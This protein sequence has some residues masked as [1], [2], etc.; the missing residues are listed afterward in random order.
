[1]KLHTETN[2]SGPLHVALVHGLGGNGATWRPLIDLMLATGKYTVTTVDLR[3]HGESE[4]ATSYVIELFAADLAENLPTGLDAIVGHSLGGPVLARAIDR[5]QPR[6]AVY[7]DPG[8]HLSL[9]VSGIAGRLFW[10]VPVLSLG[11][12]QVLQT[13]KSAGATSSYAPDV[14]A[15]LDDAHRQFDRSMAIGVFR[16][17]A[18]HPI[19][20]ATPAVPSTVILSDDSAA[21]FPDAVAAQFEDHGWTVR[22]LPDIHHDM[23]LESPARVFDELQKLL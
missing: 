13:R 19:A 18:F 10:L 12:A 16:D 17:V 20:A 9:P 7:L 4:R 2:G 3:G 22:R 6:Q 5:L 15:L 11:V 23:Q 21:V 8:F 1:M 14:R